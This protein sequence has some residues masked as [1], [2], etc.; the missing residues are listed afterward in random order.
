VLA[1]GMLVLVAGAG[2]AR[3]GN[4]EPAPPPVGLGPRVS[5]SAEDGRPAGFPSSYPT[6]DALRPGTVLQLR[7]TGF[8]P[9]ASARAMQCVTADEVSCGNAI[10]V[11]LDEDG[12]AEIQYLVTDEFT[13]AA[14]S[15]RCRAHAARCTVVVEEVDGDDRAERGTTFHDEEPPPGVIRVAPRTG[16]VDGRTVT[17]EVEGFPPGADVQA[18][19]CAA[20]AATGPQRCGAPGPTSPLRVGPEGRGRTQLE[21]RSGPV[22][23]ERVHCGRRGPGCGI[24]VASPDVFARAPVVPIAFAGPPGPTYDAW[25]LGAGLTTAALLAGAAGWFVRRTDWSPPGEAAAPEIDDAEYADLDAIVAALPPEEP[26]PGD[27]ERL[28]G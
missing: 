5:L 21:V 1:A 17:V 10:P 27:D 23:D 25:R 12:A 26:G 15:G 11:Q 8:G 18:M 13:P 9:F 3:A 22:G 28:G 16:L 7:V 24:S 19:L 14:R 4:E 2:V 20:P 6:V